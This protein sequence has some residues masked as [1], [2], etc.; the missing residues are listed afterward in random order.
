[1]TAAEITLENILCR[2]KS[3]FLLT[4]DNI[5]TQSEFV[6]SIQ[7]GDFF[8]KVERFVDDAYIASIFMCNSSLFYAHVNRADLF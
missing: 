4:Y 1:M 2:S 3:V 6:S 8:A 7:V 5:G